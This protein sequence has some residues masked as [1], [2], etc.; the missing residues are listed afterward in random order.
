MSMK[1]SFDRMQRLLYFV[2]ELKQDAGCKPLYLVSESK[3]DAG[4]KPL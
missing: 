3:L 2:S 1:E 4:R